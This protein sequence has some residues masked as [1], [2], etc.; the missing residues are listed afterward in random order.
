MIEGGP[1]TRERKFGA[2][3]HMGAK[4][5][6]V[7]PFFGSFLVPLA[8]WWLQRDSLFVGSA[9]PRLAQLSA[10]DDG[11]LLP[12]AGLRVRVRVLRIGAA[13]VAHGLR[14]GVDAQGGA[15]RRGRRLLP[16]PD[17]PDVPE[18]RGRG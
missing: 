9:R 17:V 7:I 2:V 11:L 6:E 14:V 10:V 8:V 3:A 4:V 13:R 18:G 1:T 15:A 16:L 5:G 12:R